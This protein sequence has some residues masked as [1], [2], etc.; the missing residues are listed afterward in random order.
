MI[1]NKEEILKNAEEKLKE[2]LKEYVNAMDRKSDGEQYSIDVIEADLVNIQNITREVLT[3]TTEQL[4]NSL[5]EEKEIAKKTRVQ[6][7]RNKADNKPKHC[8][9]SFDSWRKAKY[10]KKTTIFEARESQ[11]LCG[12]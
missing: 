7:K 5:D 2:A 10:Q 6:Q 8:N 12:R 9:R 4:L 1:K 3:K 11:C